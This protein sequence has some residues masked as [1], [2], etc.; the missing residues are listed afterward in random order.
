MAATLGILATALWL[1]SLP[2]ADGPDGHRAMA[3]VFVEIAPDAAEGLSPVA[4]AYL[5][6]GVAFLFGFV[7]LVPGVAGQARWSRF[8]AA[9][10]AVL[11][12]AYVA[13]A[14]VVLLFVH[15]SF[16]SAETIAYQRQVGAELAVYAVLAFVAIGYLLADRRRVFDRFVIGSLVVVA[17]WHLVS[18]LLLAAYADWE[19]RLTPVAYLATPCYL[20]IALCLGVSSYHRSRA[21]ASAAPGAGGWTPAV[22]GP[23]R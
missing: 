5:G 12:A 17:V 4:D 9:V 14:A 10:P 16:N 20:L 8:V 18:V 19:Y 13:V 15:E 1:V 22:P 7:G 21:V 6:A 2:A 3:D 11:G 23:V